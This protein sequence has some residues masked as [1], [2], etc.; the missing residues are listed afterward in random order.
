MQPAVDGPYFIIFDAAANAEPRTV[1]VRL[2]GRDV[3]TTE[4]A[5]F[6]QR[7]RLGPFTFKGKTTLTFTSDPGP[8]GLGPD[9]VGSV[10]VSPIEIR[11]AP[12]FY[13]RLNG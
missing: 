7:V 2:D 5:T 3:G 8:A 10:F 1:T 9:R 12:A 11:P 13:G 6:V 4:V